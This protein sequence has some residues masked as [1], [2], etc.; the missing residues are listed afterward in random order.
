MSLNIAFHIN[1]IHFRGVET[2]TFKYAH[3]NEELL[4]NNSIIL[5]KNPQ[6]WQYSD[7]KAIEYFKKRFNVFF[8]NNNSDIE[9]ILDNNKIDMFYAQKSGRKDGVIS[10]ARKNLIHCVFQEHEKHGERYAYISKWLGDLYSLPNVPYIVELP[11]YD[12][13]MRSELNIPKDSIV[14]GRFGGQE[15]FDIEFAKQTIIK[16][17]EKRSDIYFIF[18][19]TNKFYNHKN[20]IYLDSE[21]NEIKK[22]KFINSCDA[23]IHCRNRGE[24]F[25][26]A[27]AEFSLR[28]KPVITWTGSDDRAHLD[29]LKNNCYLYNNENDLYNILYNFQKIDKDWNMYK[30]YNPENVM[31]IFK[32]V[33]ID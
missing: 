15:T 3:Y 4:G 26:L 12:D 29:M 18:M 10:S 30:E 23:M 16:I 25:G 24:S 32:K 27:C 20:I 31:N 8:Y 11:N 6:I 7:D 21:V 22:T 19:N 2:A 33:F 5:A 17:L 28:N 9:S 13:D 1:Q 14:F